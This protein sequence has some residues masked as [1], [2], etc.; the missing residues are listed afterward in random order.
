MLLL[1]SMFVVTVTGERIKENRDYVLVP[2]PLMGGSPRHECT[3]RPRRSRALEDDASSV[4]DPR[5]EKDEVMPP[6]G[7]ASVWPGSDLERRPEPSY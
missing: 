5:Q 1:A 3:G 7:Q 6:S 2:R 4:R